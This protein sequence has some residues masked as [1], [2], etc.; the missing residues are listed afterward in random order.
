[1]AGARELVRSRKAPKPR[2]ETARLRQDVPL[3]PQDTAATVAAPEPVG[4]A[5]LALRQD[6]A[7][8]PLAEPVPQPCERC[9]RLEAELGKADARIKHL[10]VIR[11]D[12]LVL[13]ER[14]ALA[15]RV[16]ELEAEVARRSE[17]PIAPDLADPGNEPQ[18]SPAPA[19]HGHADAGDLPGRRPCG[20]LDAA[21]VVIV[22]G[23]ERQHVVAPDGEE[24]EWLCPVHRKALAGAGAMVTPAPASGDP[25]SFDMGQCQFPVPAEPA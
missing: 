6:K 15:R 10:E 18:D 14:N 19:D 23:G 8:D 7:A 1:V 17:A 16:R 4:Q 24:L 13:A 20:A 12:K 25:I 9:A 22:V 2:P 5:V 3:G 11:P 21:R